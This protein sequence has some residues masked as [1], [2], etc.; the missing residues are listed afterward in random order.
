MRSTVL[1]VL[2]LLVVLC[3]M[4]WA[5]SC[6]CSAGSYCDSDNNGACTQCPAGSYSSN[7]ATQC[8]VCDN[9]SASDQY[10]FMLMT[11]TESIFERGCIVLHQLSRGGARVPA[12]LVFL[13]LVSRRPD[14]R[15]GPE[16]P[17][18]PSRIN[19]QRRQYR[20]HRMSPRY[21]VDQRSSQLRHLP[22]RYLVAGQHYRV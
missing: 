7:G 21:R 12:K 22:S 1:W 6:D 15:V 13:R 5:A 14:L 8:T 9:V 18:L 16:L 10:D 20:M 17:V 4:A 2:L 3:T 11:V 19:E